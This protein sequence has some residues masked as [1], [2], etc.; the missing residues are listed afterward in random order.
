VTIM[1]F[2]VALAAWWGSR[3]AEWFCELLAKNEETEAAAADAASAAAKVQ[4]EH[5]RERRAY[6][7][8]A[9]GELRKALAEDTPDLFPPSEIPEKAS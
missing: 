6:F 2:T 4:A 5:W 9:R 8:R 1:Q 7:V 3:E